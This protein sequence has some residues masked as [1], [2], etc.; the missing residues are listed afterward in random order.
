MGVI[1]ANCFQSP[2][3]VAKDPNL[4]DWDVRVVDTSC[5]Y[6]YIEAGRRVP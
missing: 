5:F 4:F 6:T 2:G 1:L 3:D